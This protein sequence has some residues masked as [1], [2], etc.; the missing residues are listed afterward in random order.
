MPYAIGYNPFEDTGWY[1]NQPDGILYLDNCC[2]GYKGN[3]PTGVLSLKEGT[4]FISNAAFKDCVDLDSITI[5]N[6]V[7][8]IGE[9]AFY[10]CGNLLSITIPN[11]VVYIGK[12]A[13]EGC[14]NLNS[15]NLNSEFRGDVYMFRNCPNLKQLYIGGDINS[16]SSEMFSHCS[17]LT[18]VTISNSVTSIGSGAFMDC[19]GLTSVSIPN[20]VTTIG[21]YAFYNTGW[22]NNQPDGILYLDNCCLNYKGDSPTETLLIKEGTRLIASGALHSSKTIKIPKS[23]E[24]ITR[25]PICPLY[26]N[27]SLLRF[28]VDNKNKNYKSYKDVLFNK[29]KTVLIC[30]PNGKTGK[31]SIPNSVTSIGEFAFFYCDG[32]T[33]VTIPNSVTEIGTS[34]FFGCTNLETITI[35][36]PNVKIG[37]AS[38]PEGVKVIMDSK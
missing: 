3:E 8:S 10:N 1:N 7:T 6:S 5:P 23:V 22:Y 17:G 35:Y 26:R 28:D 29:D 30:F 15:L 19:T 2:L 31:Y 36:N 18:S 20:S 13:F 34:V 37:L 9:R 27:S 4:R 38:I 32:L 33:S 16:I 25:C 21:D 24:Y 11:S 14:N 12:G